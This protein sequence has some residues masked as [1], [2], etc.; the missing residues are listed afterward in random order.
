MVSSRIFASLLV[1]LVSSGAAN[2]WFR[3]ACTTPLVEERLDPIISP[4]VIG[5]NHAHT[6]AFYFASKDMIFLLNVYST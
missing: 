3:V 4:G 5:S 1:A 2:A 6:G